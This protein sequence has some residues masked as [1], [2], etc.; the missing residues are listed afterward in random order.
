[1]GN[2][3][4]TPCLVPN[5]K[6]LFSVAF[7]ILWSILIVG[8]GKKEEPLPAA[9]ALSAEVICSYAPSQSN[10]VSHLSAAAGGSAVAASAIAQTIVVTVVRHSS[11]AY[12]FTGASG[13][14]AGT[15]SGA[16]ALPAIVTT[17]I[18][19]AG[20][21]VSLELICAPKNYPVLVSKVENAAS[22]FAVRSKQSVNSTV[23]I[24]GPIIAD[25]KGI[26]V[27]ASA[28]AFDYAS[29]TS[30]EWSQAIRTKLK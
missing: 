15:I 6:S 29:R 21:A 23:E 24:T 26:V 17:S 19:V 3:A 25:A 28:D 9:G 13:Y 2:I 14:V 20:S 5:T 12:I 18:V 16:G 30:I 22:E 1:M 7:I 4:P 10:V 8:C 11:G 27:K